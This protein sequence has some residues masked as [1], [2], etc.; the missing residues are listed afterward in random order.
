MLKES[1]EDIN[2]QTRQHDEEIQLLNEQLQNKRD[3]DFIRFKEFVEK[4][5]N[6]AY[7]HGTPSTG[8]VIMKKISMLF[9]SFLFVLYIYS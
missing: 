5:G 2:K 8:E 1:R 6:P 3:L 4:G 7:F 9:Q